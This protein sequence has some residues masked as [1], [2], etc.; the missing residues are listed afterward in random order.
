MNS[1]PV[2]RIRNIGLMA[3]I[4]AGKTTTTERILYY[5]GV[6]YKIGEVDEGTTQMDWMDQEQERGITITAAATTCSWNDHR[7][8]IIDTP[9]HVDFT[10]EVERSLRILDGVIVVICGVGGVEPQTEKVWYQADK[11]RVPRIAYVNKMDRTGADFHDVVAQIEKRLSV[12]PLPIQLPLGAEDGFRGVIDLVAMKAYHYNGEL[13]GSSF[14]VTEIPDEELDNARLYHEQLV[15]RVAELDVELLEYF[16]E[17]KPI[18]QELLMKALRRATIDLRLVPVCLG[19][20]FKN[21]AIQNLLNA[22]VD[23]LPSPL[24]KGGV[25]GQDPRTGAP[26]ERRLSSAE[27]LSAL[28]FKIANDSF[29]GPL[30]YFRV[31]SGRMKSGETVFNSTSGERVRLA[32]ILK[33]HANKREEID[34][35]SCGD[36][37]ATVGIKNVST[38]DTLCDERHPVV[39]DTIQFPAPVMAATIEPRLT[40]DHD[41]L[42]SVLAKLSLEDPTLKSYLDRQTGQRIVSGMGE[43]HL[44]VIQERIR[45]EFGVQTKLGRPR[46]AYQE[47]V[48]TAGVG[49]GRYLKQAAGKNQF[50]H[51]VLEVSPGLE[52][53]RLSFINKWKNNLLTQ[54]CLAAIE[55]GIRESLDVGVVAGYPINRVTVNLVD[56][57][58]QESEGNEIAFK[59]AAAM[60]FRNAFANGSPILLEPIMKI[61]ILVQDEYLGEV[62]GDFNARGGRIVKIDR[63]GELQIVDGLVPLAQMFGYSKAFR[64]LTQGR[65]NYSLEFHRLE[66]MSEEKMN[67]VLRVQL[68]TI[69]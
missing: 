63:K 69:Q 8:N 60:A 62:I 16:L 24:E 4:D 30:V 7:I 20:S 19:S 59:A 55:S 17:K 25:S 32:K 26:V 22:V 18:P 28:V 29:A 9:G 40:A 10:A 45:R 42:D 52:N 61:E 36:I 43:L 67:E 12:P 47:T 37:A 34:Q 50:A 54:S 41:K 5:T 31:Y 66:E 53:G 49:E 48:R 39:L 15:E 3:H 44:E 51:V 58:V 64:T 14:E 33:M 35:V 21:K 23:Y 65:A 13:L 1:F 27:P 46:V 11:Y 57:T 6:T 2:D 68:G 56:G 38:G